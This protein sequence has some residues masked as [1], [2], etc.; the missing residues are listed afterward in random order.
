MVMNIMKL[1][2]SFAI[3]DDGARFTVEVSN[4]SGT[5]SSAAATLS[6]TAVG[7]GR[8]WLEHRHDD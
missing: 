8:Q 4:P 5:L 6:V 1:M 3:C 2:S 7:K